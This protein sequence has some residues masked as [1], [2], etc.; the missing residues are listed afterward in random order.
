[1]SIPL[2]RPHNEYSQLKENKQHIVIFWERN[3]WHK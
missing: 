3:M 1:M 2:E